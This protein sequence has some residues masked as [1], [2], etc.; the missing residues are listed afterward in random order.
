MFRRSAHPL[1]PD[2]LCFRPA[3]RKKEQEGQCALDNVCDLVCVVALGN[4]HILHIRRVHQHFV[5][6]GGFDR[7]D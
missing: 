5:G 1:Q 3:L 2:S 4:R 6:S 7:S